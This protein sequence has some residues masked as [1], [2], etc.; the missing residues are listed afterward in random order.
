MSRP[1]RHRTREHVERAMRDLEFLF[2][3]LKD[4]PRMK[5]PPIRKCAAE[6]CNTFA[7]GKYLPQA[8]APGGP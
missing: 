5:T 1:L 4:E 2:A 6:G 3:P 7:A 8:P